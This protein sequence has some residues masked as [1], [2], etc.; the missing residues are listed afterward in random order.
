[1]AY[2]LKTNEFLSSS[3]ATI[4][5]DGTLVTCMLSS[6][7]S[8]S[9]YLDTTCLYLDSS[10]CASSSSSSNDTDEDL[11]AGAIV[12]IVIGSVAF[13]VIVGVGSFFLTKHLFK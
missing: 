8:N 12:G 6:E 11:S 9:L 2:D 7:G 10:K 13:A 5:S 4:N 1:L 3:K